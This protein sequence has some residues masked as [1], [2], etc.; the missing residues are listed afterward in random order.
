MLFLGGGCLGTDTSGSATA[1]VLPSY[2]S[3]LEDA[4]ALPL[5]SSLRVAGL[6][7]TPY[8]SCCRS[9]LRAFFGAGVQPG[10]LAG[11]NSHPV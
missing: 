3:V 7:F 10:F 4:I 2:R 1:P 8:G 5:R 6:H 11:S 9:W